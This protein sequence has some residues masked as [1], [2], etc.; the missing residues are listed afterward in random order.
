MR[1][2]K[3]IKMDPNRVEV[4]PF[5]PKLCQNVA[6]RLR[7]IFQALPGLK[8][9]LTNDQKNKN[10][11]NIPIFTAQNHPLAVWKNI[12]LL[13]RHSVGAAYLANSE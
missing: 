12:F 1:Y 5:G 8:T 9:Q 2:P 11:M 7:I 4:G 13:R 3:T 6:P 10:I